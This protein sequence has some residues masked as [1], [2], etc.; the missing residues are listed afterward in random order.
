MS[1]VLAKAIW[2]SSIV[3]VALVRGPHVRRSIRIKVRTSRQ[4]LKDNV[5]VGAVSI[6]ILL[7]LLW[8]ATPV[9]AF[10]DYS[11]QPF[12]LTAGVLVLLGELWCLH[13]SHVDLG[14]NWSNTLEVRESHQLITNGV[15]RY[16]R[17]PM[18][19]SL[20]LHGL[21]QTLLLPNWVAGP[22]FLIPFGLLVALR[23]APEEQMMLDTFG[24]DYESYQARTKRLIPG[25]W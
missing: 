6:G 16:V 8:V 14:T 2:L 12:A 15:Y 20:L 9:L 13:R 17:H 21:G 25:V 23:V 7:P 10:A 3:A 5:L 11:L 4:S 18:Y 19:V 22:S 1:P 24:E